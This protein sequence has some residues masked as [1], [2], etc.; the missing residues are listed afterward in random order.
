MDAEPQTAVIH[1]PENTLARPKGASWALAELSDEEF[2]RGM[3][4]AKRGRQRLQEVMRAMMTEGIHFGKIPGTDKPTLLKPGAEVL[5]QMFDLVPSTT[6]EV[7]Y[8]DGVTAPSI[9]V[10]G[11]CTLYRGSLDGPAV[12]VGEGA[13]NSWEKK[14][15][16][17]QAE[18]IC[19]KCKKATI[20]TG[21]AEY[22]GGF[23]CWSKKGGCGAKFTAQNEELKDQ[24]IGQVENPDPYELLNTI[25]K[26][27]AKRAKLDAV[28]AGT[29]SSDL[30]TQDMDETAE[31]P[32]APP[33]EAP[34]PPTPRVAFADVPITAV[35]YGKN[36]GRPVKDL[37]IRSLLWYEAEA[38]ANLARDLPKARTYD[39]NAWL[40]GIQDE[41]FE[42]QGDMM[43]P[44]TPET[45]TEEEVLAEVGAITDE[46]VPF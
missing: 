20:I 15:R 43:R 17:R 38:Q 23:I 45:R 18:R 41:L 46:E 40:A 12:A 9:T 27:T 35:P 8:G 6:I 34:K 19:P 7:S 2:A 25:V 5:C 1:A 16:Y 26:I 30:L 31:A 42:R 14:W 22:G 28:I 24:E 29:A 36:A 37:T 13:G 11:R 4:M 21:K 44:R 3:E 33:K 39:E 10:R 32:P